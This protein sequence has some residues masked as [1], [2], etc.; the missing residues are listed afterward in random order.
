MHENAQASSAC[1]HIPDMMDDNIPDSL[2]WD[3]SLCIDIG[4]I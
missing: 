3:Q 2:S 1:A 4:N